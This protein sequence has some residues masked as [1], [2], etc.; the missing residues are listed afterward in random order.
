MALWGKFTLENTLKLHSKKVKKMFI[1]RL[2]N[3]YFIVYFKWHFI[4]R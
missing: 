1:K 2:V 3:V 4:F